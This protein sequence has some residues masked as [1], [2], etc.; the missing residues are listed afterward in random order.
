MFLSGVTR[1]AQAAKTL[2][3]H[4]NDRLSLVEKH[5]VD[6]K[7]DLERIQI[8]TDLFE[9]ETLVQWHLGMLRD[10]QA[11]MNR[12]LFYNGEEPGAGR[13]LIYDDGESVDLQSFNNDLVGSEKERLLRMAALHRKLRDLYFKIAR[14]VETPGSNFHKG[15][16][17]QIDPLIDQIDKQL[18][19]IDQKKDLVAKDAEWK[20]HETDMTQAIDE[21]ERAVSQIDEKA[22]KGRWKRRLR[23]LSRI[24]LEWFDPV[25]TRRS[26]WTP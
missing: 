2:D 17:I 16:L 9:R 14:K 5:Q 3:I 21:L 22:Q 7:M 6:L 12:I 15:Y 25:Q 1:P 8:E 26:F 23:F 24:T 10:Y 19:L 18:I 13:R 4:R 11:L 20:N